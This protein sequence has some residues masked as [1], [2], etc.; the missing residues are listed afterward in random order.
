MREC[1]GN[2][3]ARRDFGKDEASWVRMQM[4]GAKDKAQG[5]TDIYQE[6][7]RW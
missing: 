5:I 4:K 7:S 6:D 2:K 1:G 3:A